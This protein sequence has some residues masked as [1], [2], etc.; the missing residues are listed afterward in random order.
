MHDDQAN[1]LRRLFGAP[2]PCLLSVAGPGVTPVTVDL[3]AALARLGRR[4]LL[5]DRSRGEAASACGLA[6][7][8][9][10]AH[11]IAGDKAWRDVVLGGPDGIAIM[12][13]A[14]AL[15]ALDRDGRDWQAAITG[16]ALAAGQ[17]FDVWLLNGPPAVR[18][19]HADVLL[20]ITPTATAITGAYAQIK[21][22]ALDHGRRDFRV[23]V[24]RAQS[25]AAALDA[26]RSFAETAQRYL[27]ARLDFCGTIP[28]EGP[29][30]RTAR[31]GVADARSPRG[32]AFLRLAE[33]I[34]AAA[35]PQPAAL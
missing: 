29:A 24:H 15:D 18:G 10:L 30:S 26:Y 5:L 3:A 2:T 34:A 6:V 32:H 23:V 33:S 9:E 7:R 13:A 25:E 12:P 22:L 8:Y 20:P 16:L 31:R 11:V 14:R 1:G 35:V 28:N 19:A 4:V 27:S 17:Q 21:R